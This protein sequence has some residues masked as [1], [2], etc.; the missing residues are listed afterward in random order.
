MKNSIYILLFLQLL[1]VATISSQI[2]PSIGEILNADG[3]VRLGRD[4]GYDLEGY[5]MI[6]DK[7]GKPSFLN[8]TEDALSDSGSWNSVGTGSSNGVSGSGGYV[9]SI[10]ALAVYNGELYVGGNFT[11]AGG[12]SANRIARWNGNSWNSVGTGSA[13]GVSA[14]GV[15]GVRA[16]AVYNGELYVGGFFSSAGGVSVNNIARWNGS[17][18][19]SVGTGSANG[20]NGLVN[21]LAVYNGE[22]YVGGE[23]TSAGGVSA[24]Y[25]A[26]WNGTSWNSVGKGSG[27]GVNGYVYA[28]AVY[29]EE[30]YVGGSFG[31][32]GGV[33]ANYIARWNGTSWDSVGTSSG[34]GV[35]GGVRALA[36]YNGELYV[37]GNFT[38]ANWT[39]SNPTS[40][41]ANNIARWNG[42]A[43]NSVG[44]GSENGVSITG[45]I[46][47][48]YALAVYNGELYV[49][50]RFIRAGTVVA[51]RIARWNGNNW[52]SL[53]MINSGV[54]SGDYVSSLTTYNNELY[55][56]G[57]FTEAGGISANR[58]ARWTIGDA[59]DV[60]ENALTPTNFVLHQNYP[61]PFNPSTTISFTIPKSS[62]V[63]LKVYDVL[64]REVAELVNGD[65]QA[66]SH[67]INFD[68]SRL[69][70]GTYFYRLQ[71]GNGV[72]MK[73]MMLIK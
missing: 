40:I 50:G 33:S 23:F 47:Y 67:S 28:L 64:G 48:V 30:L 53:T 57:D 7:D 35:S 24:N 43:W 26:R 70:S 36:V 44:T 52:N 69:S 4:G 71:A 58:I 5:K 49:G 13:N 55:V 17:G 51:G 62:Y 65:L 25:I 59:T 15:N 42:N 29:N 39:G 2:Q 72:K 27:N 54:S 66:G 18:W 31:S 3:T 61:N 12:K 32:A 1:F 38:Y 34:N 60:E 10:S 56:G 73:K 6:I 14:V 9:I 22:L 63:T 16:L 8:K 45:L 41:R 68:A 37:G 19:N 11:F 21:A 46:P 20:V